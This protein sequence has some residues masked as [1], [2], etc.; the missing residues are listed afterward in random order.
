MGRGY[1]RNMFGNLFVKA[2]PAIGTGAIGPF[3]GGKATLSDAE[4]RAAL[5]TVGC[6][7][8]A[9]TDLVLQEVACWRGYVRADYVCL[10]PKTLSVVEIKSDRDSL[11]RFDEQI[12]I[13]SAVAD[14]V[15]LVVGW[16]LAAHALR[17]APSWW[18]VVLAEREPTF[19]IRFVPLRDGGPNPCVMA[20]ALVAMLPLDEVRHLASA[21]GGSIGRVRGPALRKAVANH[22]S[23]DALRTAV[24]D[25]LRRLP[26]RRNTIA[27]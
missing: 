9:E 19:D 12:R 10:G 24:R 13:Y 4:I 20:E 27:S 14:R 17:A 25:W 18:D 21:A 8:L 5:A 23:R 6:D 22:L 3:P 16:S 26:Q 15:T 11:R 7:S 2:C 1:V